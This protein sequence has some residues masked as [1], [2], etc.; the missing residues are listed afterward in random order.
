MDDDDAFL[1]GD[2][3]DGQAQASSSAAVT[4][5]K[6]GARCVCVSL[7]H[8]S[9]IPNLTSSYSDTHSAQHATAQNG[10][11]D[12]QEV[13]MEEE[14]E[15]DDLEIILDN[16]DAAAPSTAQ[17]PSKLQQQ[18][19]ANSRFQK[20]FVTPSAYSSNTAVRPLL[21]GQRPTSP[22][23]PYP[24]PQPETQQSRAQDEV[25]PSFDSL[26][27][28]LED[29]TSL[30]DVDIDSL[31]EKPWRA[32]GAHLADYFNYNLDEPSWKMYV[33]RQ[34]RQRHETED[35]RNHPFRA[36]AELPVQEAWNALPPESKGLLM[37]TVMASMPGPNPM[38]AMMMAA[39]ANMQQQN[40]NSQNNNE[41]QNNTMD[42]AISDAS[43]PARKRQRYDDPDDGS[44]NYPPNNMM[45][46]QMNMGMPPM[47]MMM[48]PPP[49]MDPSMF[50]MMGGN[51]GGGGG[52]GRGGN[53]YQGGGQR[54][55]PFG[56]QPNQRFPHQQQRNN[57]NIADDAES[58]TDTSQGGLS[59]R[60]PL[61]PGREI[62]P[63]LPGNVPTGPR[64]NAPPTGPRNKAS[65]R[66]KDASGGAFGH[67]NDGL[68]YGSSALPNAGSAKDGSDR[69]SR[70]PNYDD[71]DDYRDSSRA[72][73]R[74]SRSRRSPS[75]DRHHSPP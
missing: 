25:A 16:P 36:F 8:S 55:N 71:Y 2:A 21:P 45:G 29:N 32:P 53:R 49:G 50:M 19:Q 35:N 30:F 47:G 6:D 1:Y 66:D 68:D 52:R 5:T 11:D 23:L 46:Q 57:Y 3:S 65:Y 24:R 28:V 4:A 62:S 9:Q 34:K 43:G 13:P 10:Q 61:P 27:A 14:D 42:D 59:G 22:P 54:N 64:R 26:P 37:Q 7:T 51:T 18:Q 75:D 69:R 33:T 56:M 67:V 38:A 12:S 63:S 70:S 17:Q 31:P 48:M 41:N 44:N 73:Q 74:S 39:A 20:T 60:A 72:T 15:D 40:N 58:V